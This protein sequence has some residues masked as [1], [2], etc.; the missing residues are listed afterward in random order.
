M[1]NKF[2]LI[3]LCGLIFNLSFAQ[4]VWKVD[5][6]LFSNPIPVSFST[7]EGTWMN[8]DLSPDGKTLAFDL[9][10]DIY[11]LD[12]KGGKAKCILSGPAWEVQPRF[13]PDGK[14]LCFTSDRDGADNIWVCDLNGKNLKSI[15]K[16]EFRLLNNPVWS[17]DGKYIVARKHFT[18][19][20]SAGAGEMW[21]YHVEGG[22]GQALTTRKNDQQDVN[23]PFFDPTGKFLYFSEDMYPGGYF[24][25]NKNPNDQIYVTQRYDFESGT[26]SVFIGGAGGS[27]R[28]TPSHNSKK[29]AFVRRVREASVLMVR[30]L[31]TG[32]ETQVYDSLS[33]DQQE[34]WA[35]FGVYPG[36][37]WSPDDQY[38]FIW[39]QGKIKKIDVRAGKATDVPFEAEVKQALKP[40]L[41]FEQPALKET[42][43][44]KALRGATTSSTG[45]LA[46]VAA[47]QLWIGN[48][49]TLKPV[50]GLPGLANDP[51]WSADGQT[52]YI[53]IWNDT[54]LGSIWTVSIKNGQAQNPKKINLPPGIYRYPKPSPS[55]NAMLFV[56][57]SG[58][59]HLGYAHSNNPGIY[60]FTFKTSAF[61]KLT[62]SGENPWWK[63]DESGFY[64]QTGG[65]IFGSQSKTFEQYSFKE[66]TKVTLSQSKYAGFYAPSP[67]GKYV[68]F[69]ELYK[70]Y[71][72][73]MPSSGKPLS[74]SG[75]ATELPIRCISEDA[76]ISL[77]W[78]DSKTLHWTLG[79]W[80]STLPLPTDF[81][82]TDTGLVKNIRKDSLRIELQGNAPEQVVYIKAGRII[83]MKGQEVL[84]PGVLLI[85]NNRIA[86]VGTPED[87][88]YTEGKV[89]DYSDKTLMPG[90]VDVHAH[91]G[92]FRHGISPEQ[93]WEYFANLAFGVTTTHDPSAN[94]EMVF[95][96]SEMLR[97][98][99]MLGP[100]LFST[101]T[102]LYGAE[103]DFKAVINSIDDARKA[104]QRNKAFGAFSVKSYNQPRRNQRQQVIQAAEEEHIRVV[105][106][107]GSHFFHNMTMV[108]DGHTGVEHNIPVAPL[109]K[110]VIQFWSAGKTAN[111]PTLIVNYGGINGEYYWFQKTNVW[112]NKRLLQFSPRPVID[113]RSRHRTMIPDEE[114][115]NGHI[116]VSKSCTKL[117]NAGVNINMG[118]HGQL[119]GL[120]AHWE[121]WM[122][123][124]GGMSP[125][126]TLRAAT[127]NG[128]EYIG[129]DKELGSL[130]PGKLA[131]ILVLNAN[132]LKNIQ[133]TL[134]IYRVILNGRFYNPDNLEEEISGQFRP[135]PFYWQRNHAFS[136]PWVEG[137]DLLHHH[138]GCG[139]H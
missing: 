73:P 28:P 120:G 53:A 52:V 9:L 116:L 34:A 48:N 30:D 35:I 92:N 21:L 82:F 128:A 109:Y 130:E 61:E 45:N 12:A 134:D 86:A 79:P 43:A 80:Y 104:I 112:E 126:Q 87:V 42:F 135:K 65:I 90:M 17:P 55:G 124:Q 59:G 71:L 33:K 18:S 68:A 25:Y 101:G 57:E 38:I 14:L 114:Y 29:L 106:E 131:D 132:P 125:M 58:N 98:G 44:S 3:A 22:K 60:R 93:Q 99:R 75:T 102:I 50:Q 26:S 20:R 19:S 76:G 95:S 105:P 81:Q 6:N 111:T 40:A 94:T 63:P 103:G 49:Q 84:E 23:E 2:N 136:S 8:L 137:E 56:K 67:D 127:L 13:S 117:Q 62:D 139:K 24:Q 122:L 115:E 41:Q 46:V 100:R 108:M 51:A 64:F 113:A 138:C 27:V 72:M 69:S 31:E 77:H 10:G 37:A 1:K 74:I 66:K 70:V 15:T 107:G 133:N 129:M 36:F 16:E 89:I 118:S 119:Q 123:H 11:L 5:S 88:P 91:T 97:T 110:D 4:S 85:K 78:S 83:T 54:D 7:N 47:G 39:A 121:T 32:A 96:Q